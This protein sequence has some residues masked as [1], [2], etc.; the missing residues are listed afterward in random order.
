MDYI[1]DLK[2]LESLYLHFNSI[3]NIKLLEDFN[4]LTHLKDLRIR[5]NPIAIEDGYRY[6]IVK[7]LTN[8]RI[9]DQI[10]IS[11]LDREG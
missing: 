1:T 7:M 10:V 9:L 6:F 8:I 3:A 2:K 5:G 4:Y 11:K